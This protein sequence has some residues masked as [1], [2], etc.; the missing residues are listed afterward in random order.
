MVRD[1][2]HQEAHSEKSYKEADR[3]QEQSAMGT[4]W[5]L[6]MDQY[7]QPGQVKDKKNEGSKDCGERKKNPRS[8]YVHSL[9]LSRRM[10]LM[11]RP[12]CSSRGPIRL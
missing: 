10:A 6:L 9:A 12:I 1:R 3:S 2:R 5:Y 11:A 8:G 7:S 4:I